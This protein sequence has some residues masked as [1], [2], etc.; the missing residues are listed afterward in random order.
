MK[1]A[2]ILFFSVP[3]DAIVRDIVNEI[4]SND[5]HGKTVVD[6]STIHPD[7]TAE[8][9]QIITSRWARFVACPVFGA[10][11]MADS[12]DLICNL[13]A[14]TGA[15]EKVRPYCDG[16]MSSHTIDLSRMEPSNATLMK[17]VGN[18]FVLNM[19]SSL[20]TMC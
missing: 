10:A 11:A 20:K 4:T 18:T 13:A 2:D 16:V 14:N 15:T 3:D 6:C 17:I 5:I 9:E 7:T 1:H 8:G 19:M 12:G